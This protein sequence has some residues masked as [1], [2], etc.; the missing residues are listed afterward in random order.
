MLSRYPMLINEEYI[1]SQIALFLNAHGEL[2]SLD[3]LG[4]KYGPMGFQ[5]QSVKQEIIGGEKP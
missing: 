4:W 5:Q 1:L 3:G 2:I